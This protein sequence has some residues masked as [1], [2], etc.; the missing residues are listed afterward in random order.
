MEN[1]Y[2][3]KLAADRPKRLLEGADGSSTFV[4]VGPL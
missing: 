3:R 4:G 2:A 1:G